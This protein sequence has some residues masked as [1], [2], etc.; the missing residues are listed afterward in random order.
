MFDTKYYKGL[1]K[2]MQILGILPYPHIITIICS[3]CVVVIILL[4]FL[5][6]QVR[7]L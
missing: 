6:P 1:I 3:Q 5:I 2:L 7:Q 4:S